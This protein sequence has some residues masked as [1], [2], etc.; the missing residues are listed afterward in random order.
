MKKKILFLL[1]VLLLICL[2]ACNNV[3]KSEVIKKSDNIPDTN[4]KVDNTNFTETI[5]LQNINEFIQYT[6]DLS[7]FVPEGWHLLDSIEESTVIGDLNKDEIQDIAFVIERTAT[8]SEAPPRMLIIIKGNKDNSYSLLVKV[9]KAI[10][11]ADE[12]GIMGDPFMGLGIDRGSLLI[13]HYGGSAWRWGNT[14]RFRYQEDGF[15]L[16]GATEDWFHAVSGAGRIYEDINLLTGDYIRIETDDNGVEKKIKS[17]R[18]RKKLVNLVDF[19]TNGERQ[20]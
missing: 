10:L 20:F 6:V 19:D 1:T 12:G 17:N 5:E 8:E 11:R 2:V 4:T 16:I 3:Q 18:G 15:Y 7:T 14:Y 9:E 13:S